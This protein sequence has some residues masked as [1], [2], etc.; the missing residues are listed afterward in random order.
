MIV[1]KDRLLKTW[2]LLY[3]SPAMEEVSL[4]LDDILEVDRLQIHQ[5]RYPQAQSLNQYS[6]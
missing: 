3:G 2:T 6:W 5:V 1:A 4:H